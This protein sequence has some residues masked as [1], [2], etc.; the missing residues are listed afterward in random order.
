M[1]VA[2]VVPLMVTM[3]TAL[4]CLSPSIVTSGEIGYVQFLRAVGG[5]GRRGGV[6]HCRG[7]GSEGKGGSVGTVPCCTA[8]PHT[9]PRPLMMA[10]SSAVSKA[11]SDTG[12]CCSGVPHLTPYSVWV[13]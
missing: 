6:G 13:Y 10:P 9:C 12:V 8:S 4:G 11:L 1:C 5:E 2:V 7:E 3:T